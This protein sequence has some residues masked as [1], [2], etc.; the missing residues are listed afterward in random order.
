MSMSET[1]RLREVRL[2][3]PHTDAGVDYPAGATIFVE[4]PVARWL[5]EHGIGE[6]VARERSRSSPRNPT[7]AT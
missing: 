1:H 2:A 7:N 4:E 6:P 3:Q 5:I